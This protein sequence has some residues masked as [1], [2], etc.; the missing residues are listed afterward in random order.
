MRGLAVPST[1]G[2]GLAV[3]PVTLAP[4]PNAL[5]R[6]TDTEGTVEYATQDIEG[7]ARLVFTDH[8]GQYPQF[9][10][11]ESVPAA[12]LV[13]PPYMQRIAPLEALQR[14]SQAISD[15]TADTDNVKITS[16]SVKSATLHPTINTI[17]R[18]GRLVTLS[19][20][21]KDG[22]VGS[23]VIMSLPTWARPATSIMTKSTMGAE[24]FIRSG[25]S[26]DI[27]GYSMVA[28]STVQYMDASWYTDE[29]FPSG[30]YTA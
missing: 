13:A 16:A 5:L 24:M 25:A 8:R 30:P 14:A 9:Q 26:N 3:D 19:L 6:V 18:R 27:Y 4:V 20:G 1:F 12:L 11:P 29:L 23:A 10:I 17:R 15:F 28:S 2:P 21:W 7:N 22:P